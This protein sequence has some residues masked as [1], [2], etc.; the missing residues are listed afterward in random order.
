MIKIL[1]AIFW[2]SL[3]TLIVMDRLESIK[4]LGR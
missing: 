4:R 1:F 2:V 3:L